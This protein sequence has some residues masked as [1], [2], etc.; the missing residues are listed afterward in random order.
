[1]IK[2]TPT[3]R[4]FLVGVLFFAACLNYADRGAVNSL[5][6]ILKDELGMSE[7]ALAAT[8][9]VFLW[10]YALF[11]PLAGYLGDQ[12]SRCSLVVWSLTAWSLIT[13][14]TGLALNGSQI[15]V[16]R[17]L[18]GIAEC[19]YVP[20]SIALIADHHPTSTRA[21][22]LAIH[23]CG[24][25]LG[26]VVG[27]TVAGFIGDKYGWRAPLFALG[28]TGLA[29][30]AFAKITLVDQPPQITFRTTVP[31]SGTTSKS[32]RGALLYPLR[33]ASYYILTIDA[34]L[35]AI[36]TY[37]LIT[38]LPLYFNETFRVSLTESGFH[39]TFP[40]QA[41][42]VAGLLLGGYISDSVARRSSRNRMLIHSICYFLAAP[43]L[44]AFLW[45]ER[46]PPLVMFIF[47]FST[48][49]AIGQSN[50]N[51]LLCEIVA[52]GHRSAAVGMMNLFTC[53]AAGLG[54][55]ATGYLKREISMGT[56]LGSMSVI[57]L[58]AGIILLVGYR[59]FLSPDLQRLSRSTQ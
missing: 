28:M 20:V 5:F 16:M 57:V 12:L 39:G 22:A 13:I 15:L 24:F 49:R 44:L 35:I 18:L 52:E 2:Q 27:G 14:L 43:L 25:Y 30:A 23:L 46:I 53:V 42:N 40:M 1:M 33:I 45:V 21:K 55:L 48:V 29:L 4:W 31:S 56:I 6:P 36:S 59:C 50:S 37:V 8:G 51:P 17:A 3:Y 11:S 54:V 7:V 47:M 10:T 58:L 32:L 26:V 34:F 41:G 38:W 19:L 9:S